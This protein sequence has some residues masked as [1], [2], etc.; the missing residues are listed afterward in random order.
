M[1]NFKVGGKT[2]LELGYPK[3]PVFRTAINV[4]EE[5]FSHLTRDEVIVIL[6]NVLADP[7]AYVADDKLSKIAEQLLV[8]EAP[9]EIALRETPVPYAVF[10]LEHIAD[11]AIQQLNNAVR[12]PVAVAGSLMPDAH[13]GYGL[14][15]GG[16]LAADNAV[17]PYGVGVDIG[18]R[19]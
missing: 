19:M 5:H 12:L 13:Q 8:P 14:P 11:G 7:A 3:S 6:K 1:S 2:L 17:I 15:I 9:V 4:M 18:C 10:G 16:V